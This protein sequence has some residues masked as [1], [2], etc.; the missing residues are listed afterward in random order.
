[1]F[2]PMPLMRYSCAPSVARTRT[3]AL[4]KRTF[5]PRLGHACA[6][7]AKGDD[8]PD[9]SSSGSRLLLPMLLSTPAI[10]LA[11]IVLRLHSVVHLRQRFP[12]H[13]SDL[14][15]TFMHVCTGYCSFES[16]Y[17]FLVQQRNHGAEVESLF[18]K[19][20][21]KRGID[22]AS[23]DE[24]TSSAKPPARSSPPPQLAQQKAAPSEIPQLE[25]SRALAREGLEGLIPRATELIRLGGGFFLA[26]VPFILLVSALFTGLYYVRSPGVFST[27]WPSQ[28]T[29]PSIARLH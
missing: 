25:R 18:A 13:C 23:V 1:M 9:S 24:D 22:S 12:I 3:E 7:R 10:V 29:P 14:G 6:C 2:S 4:H 20:L 28:L 11:M 19:E 21:A 16:V 8:A 26:F 27:Q 5:Q 17:N 15:S